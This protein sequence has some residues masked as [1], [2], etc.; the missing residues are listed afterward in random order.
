MTRRK[1]FSSLHTTRQWKAIGGL[2]QIWKRHLR[3]EERTNREQARY[4]RTQQDQLIAKQRKQYSQQMRAIE[5]DEKHRNHEE[6][7]REAEN[8]NQELSNYLSELTTILEQGLRSS[9]PVNFNDLRKHEEFPPLVTPLDLQKT[10][11]KPYK[12]AYCGNISHPG[13]WG[14]IFPKILKDYQEKLLQAENQFQSAQKQYENHLAWREAKIEELRKQYES[15]KKAF[16]KSISKHNQGID[17]LE[18]LYA[19]G[20]SDAVIKYFEI[21]LG[22]SKYPKNFPH[23]FRIAFRAEPKELVIEYE[24]PLPKVIPVIAEYRFI[25]S[26]G[27]IDKKRRKASE[28]KELYQDIVATCCLRTLSEIFDAD[29][30]N[31]VQVVAFNG[32]VN[33]TDPS[34]GHEIQPH[35]IS[36]QTTKENFKNIILDRIDKP[37]CL[38]NLGA[39]VSPHP[40]EMLPVKPI[41]EFNMVDKR[42]VNESDVLSDLESRPN[43]M[44]LD[45]FEFENLISNLFGKMGLSVKQTRPSR[46]S[47]VDAIAFDTRPILGGKVVIQAKR[48]KNVVGVSAV[49]DLYGTMI[50]EGANKG[51]LVTT[52]HYGTDAYDFKQDKPIELIDG[53]NLLYLLKQIG[54][55]ARIIMPEE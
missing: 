3:A 5:K 50:N 14:Y 20:N 46:D 30:G 13:F 44:D 37:S 29:I 31:C 21:V 41:V 53:S 55:K 48:Y 18:N 49:R 47:G 40:D 10:V 36:I 27:V 34:T 42:F 32:F 43:L 1:I 54:Y 9:G 11:W 4:E 8:K 12:E 45:P 15:E 23:K 33:T 28:I 17:E 2:L 22:K 7:L 26:R 19:S 6:L 51:I 52:S 25:K 35:L 16:A 24:L 39:Q 38:R